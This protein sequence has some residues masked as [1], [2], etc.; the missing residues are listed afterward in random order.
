MTSVPNKVLGY[1]KITGPVENTLIAGPR[2]GRLSKNRDEVLLEITKRDTKKIY[3]YDDPTA[4]YF[5]PE[6]CWR[7]KRLPAT[8]CG[9]EIEVI[10]GEDTCVAVFETGNVNN[11]YNDLTPESPPTPPKVIIPPP[12]QQCPDGT[13]LPDEFATLPPD[14][15]LELCRGEEVINFCPDG[16]VPDP[17][18]GCGDTEET[19]PEGYRKFGFNQGNPC[20]GNCC[21]C[22][23]VGHC[24][25]VARVLAGFDSQGCYDR[26]ADTSDPNSEELP[27]G[28]AAWDDCLIN[29]NPFCECPI[30][31]ENLNCNDPANCKKCNATRTQSE[32]SFRVC[33]FKQILACYQ[34]EENGENYSGMRFISEGGTEILLEANSANFVPISVGNDLEFTEEELETCDCGKS[35]EDGF[36]CPVPPVEGDLCDIETDMYQGHCGRGYAYYPGI[37]YVA[38]P[39]CPLGTYQVQQQVYPKLL[40]A[41]WKIGS[42]GAPNPGEEL[43]VLPVGEPPVGGPNLGGGHNGGDCPEQVA[44]ANGCEDGLECLAYLSANSPENIVTPNQNPIA[45][46]DPLN[47][48]SSDCDPADIPF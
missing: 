21:I 7:N 3:Y 25:Y 8:D 5:M 48:G 30:C 28:E 38:S 6:P 33:C 13:V 16:S 35:F 40:F 42:V 26:R 44:C 10:C 11:K 22:G 32:A 45:G 23:D 9:R 24:I 27:Q 36:P 20:H 4:K 43:E 41:W 37:A 46:E 2:F 19:C 47:N 39:S 1:L 17:D 29:P 18:T 12:K 34:P 15:Y 14:E 31:D